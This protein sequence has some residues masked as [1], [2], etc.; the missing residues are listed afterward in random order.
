MEGEE[1]PGQQFSFAFRGVAITSLAPAQSGVEQIL[2]AIAEHV[3]RIDH[4]GQELL[5][6]TFVYSPIFFSKAAAT[7]LDVRQLNHV[8]YYGQSSV[9]IRF[10]R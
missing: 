7:E 9:T 2:H 4:D 1:Q 5:F 8:G 10:A 3:E 6:E